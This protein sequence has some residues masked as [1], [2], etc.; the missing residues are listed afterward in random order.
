M[1]LTGY[2]PAPEGVQVAT[3]DVVSVPT[4]RLTTLTATA[5]VAKRR[6]V[7][8]ETHEACKGD[9][10]IAGDDIAYESFKL[11]HTCPP[12]TAYS[13]QHSARYRS[14][15]GSHVDLRRHGRLAWCVPHHVS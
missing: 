2:H 14:V 3:G 15:V 6:V 9:R 1:E 7:K 13:V 11:A 12:H 10:P 5:V 8:R 4:Q